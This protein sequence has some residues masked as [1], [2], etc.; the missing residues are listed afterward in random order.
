[1]PVINS[2]KNVQR[3]RKT[4]EEEDRVWEE[5]KAK[6]TGREQQDGTE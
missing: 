1:M 4:P 6:V 3:E 2:A 5:R